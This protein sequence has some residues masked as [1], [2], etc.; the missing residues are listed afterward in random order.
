MFVPLSVSLNQ[1]PAH[2]TRRVSASSAPSRRVP[3]KGRNS[4]PRILFVILAYGL[5][6]LE[7]RFSYFHKYCD[8]PQATFLLN[9]WLFERIPGYQYGSPRNV[10][11]GFNW[12][13]K[14]PGRFKRLVDY[15]CCLIQILRFRSR[16]DL[17]IVHFVNA[18][19]IVFRDA[20]P[21]RA[22]CF[23]FVD[24]RVAKSGAVEKAFRY[25]LQGGVPCDILSEVIRRALAGRYPDHRMLHVAPCSFIDYD[26]L[27]DM[28]EKP[29]N[30][31]GVCY[32]G[33]LIEDKGY[34]IYLEAAKSIVLEGK[35]VHFYLLA[36]GHAERQVR[37]FVAKNNLGCNVECF[38]HPSPPMIMARTLIFCSLQTANNYPSQSLLEAMA[39]ENAIVATDVGETRQ[40]V[41]P[42]EGLLIPP[43]ASALADALRE[44]VEQPMKA[45]MLGKAASAKVR[46]QH[47]V[48]I[49][50]NYLADMH[51]S[52]V[53]SHVDESRQ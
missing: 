30:P 14:R 25:L 22:R 19:S 8:N 49:Y 15:A 52:I 16:H 46:S 2:M 53:S 42:E 48:E 37:E 43:H 38:F 27:P 21:G 32:A 34:H 40:L 51:R 23:S 17:D 7:K 6:G 45:V 1:L 31:I 5:G 36:R 41:G 9:R 44:L 12:K 35:N 28:Q 18:N 47:K 13:A 20:F 11:V 26:A 24:S 33:R 50:A 29:L 39:C 3:A 10:I 4:Q